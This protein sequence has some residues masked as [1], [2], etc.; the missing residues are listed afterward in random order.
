[1]YPYPTTV[2][3]HLRKVYL[4]TEFESETLYCGSASLQILKKMTKSVKKFWT[5]K[6][7]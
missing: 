5:L 7:K 6:S 2:Y 4:N 3:Q 1:M